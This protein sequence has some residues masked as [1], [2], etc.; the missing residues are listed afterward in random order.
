ML[1][2]RGEYIKIGELWLNSD[3]DE[4]YI[5]PYE[6]SVYCHDIGKNQI[7]IINK[8]IT[9]EVIKKNNPEKFVFVGS[10]ETDED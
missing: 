8:N 4:L 10:Y 9:V 1:E 6:A 3:G 7:P 2:L 5:R